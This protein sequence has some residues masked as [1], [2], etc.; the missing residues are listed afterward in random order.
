MPV[1]LL[2]RQTLGA[3]HLHQ[4]FTHAVV[5][6][7]IGWETNRLGLNG[8]IHVDA[9]Q[10]RG[11]NHACAYARLDRGAQHLLSPGLTQPAAPTRHARRIDRQAMLEVALTTEMLPIRIFNPNSNHVLIAQVMLIL[12]VMKCH[13]QTRRDPRSTMAGDDTSLQEWLR[14]NSSRCTAQELS[15]GGACR[16]TA[17]GQPGTSLAAG[18]SPRGVDAFISPVFTPLA[19]TAGKF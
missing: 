10:L 12:Q 19:S 1:T 8:R 5:E 2:D 17:P 18:A 11:A 7:C 9:F 15:A 4:P 14:M 13:H 16:L 6:P 3:S